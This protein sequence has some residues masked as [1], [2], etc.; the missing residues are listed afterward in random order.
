MTALTPAE[1]KRRE[2]ER[3]RAGLRRVVL[4]VDEVLVDDVLLLTGNLARV[5]VDDPQKV[6]ATFS[7]AVEKWAMEK[8]AAA[9]AQRMSRVTTYS[10]E[11]CDDS[12]Q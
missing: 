10:V 11:M 8:I 12:D 4:W 2:R 5:D 7:A 6:H 3:K 1:R 9:L